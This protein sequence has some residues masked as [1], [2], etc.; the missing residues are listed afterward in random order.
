M[1]LLEGGDLNVINSFA[2]SSEN[3][4]ADK[5]T[6]KS[7][8][9]LQQLMAGDDMPCI[10]ADCNNAG[11]DGNTSKCST[12]KGHHCECA[13]GFSGFT[14]TWNEAAKQKA[15]TMVKDA[16]KP[17]KARESLIVGYKQGMEAMESLGKDPNMVNQ[18]STDSQ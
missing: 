6:A 14:C 15:N 18:E 11:K 12:V 9:R 5:L 4:L 2:K 13:T 17:M 10:P 1:G 16:L 8:A 3:L 7:I